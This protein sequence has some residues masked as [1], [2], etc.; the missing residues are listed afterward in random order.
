MADHAY[1]MTM[2]RAIGIGG[3]VAGILD[4]AAAIAQSALRGVAP[5]RV[6]QSVAA[7]LLGRESYQ[8]GAGTAGLG[9]ALHFFIAYTVT[10]VYYLASRRIPWLVRKPVTAGVLYGIGVFFAMNRIVLPLSNFSGGGGAFNLRAALSPIA[11][12]IVC[13][14]LPIALAIRRYAPL[15]FTDPLVAHPR[16]QTDP[17]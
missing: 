4:I 12:H 6:L 17:A 5:V 13:V 15:P 10:A 1:W 16:R 2:K 14:G 7:G 11:I 3:L 8:G 9:L